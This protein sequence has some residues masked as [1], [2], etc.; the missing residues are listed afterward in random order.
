MARKQ[1]GAF[2]INIV[3][4]CKTDQPTYDLLSMLGEG[5]IGLGIRLMAASLQNKESRSRATDTPLLTT[6]A[7]P[8]SRKS[9]RSAVQLKRPVRELV[10]E[11]DD[12]GRR[13]NFRVQARKQQ[14]AD[15]RYEEAMRVYLLQ[16]E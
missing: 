15:E 8:V 12:E 16:Q 5:N 3:I 2:P 14:E 13:Y 6:T 7:L 9:S 1:S 4:H 10:P 11:V